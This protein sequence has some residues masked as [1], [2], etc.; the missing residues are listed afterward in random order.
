MAP[1]AVFVNVP[2]S[3]LAS[4]KLNLSACTIT[5]MFNVS[6][7]ALLPAPPPSPPLVNPAS[8]T[9][10][11]APDQSSL[12]TPLTLSP[13]LIHIQPLQG[14]IA[15]WSDP[16]IAADNPNLGMALPAEPV[17][18][19]YR[20]GASGTNAVISQYFST[21][22]TGRGVYAC[23][24]KLR[25]QVLYFVHPS[26]H[27]GPPTSQVCTQ[28]TLGSGKT[29]PA[30]GASGTW[31]KLAV[32]SASSATVTSYIQSTPW[33]IGY[34]DAGNGHQIGLMEVAQKNL[35]GN[36]LTTATADVGAAA[37]Q[38][39]LAGGWPS[40]PVADFSGEEHCEVGQ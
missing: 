9:C 29:L 32:G 8:C 25:P 24:P 6:Q 27:T 7:P 13:I 2:S 11:P 39:F 26:S 37:T 5:N 21:V 12:I 17:M 18:P 22:S 19:V 3:I 1:I 35:D 15:T 34:A 40:N 28:W 20:S 16:A 14:A 36:W 31:S 4:Q 10:Q 30:P 23:E 33:S 38:L